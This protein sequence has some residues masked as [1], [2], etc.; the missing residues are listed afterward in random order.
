MRVCQFRLLDADGNEVIRGSAKE[1]KGKGYVNLTSNLFSY[2]VNKCLLKKKYK[3]EQLPDLIIK[4]KSE[5]RVE[6]F[7]SLRTIYGFYESDKEIVRGTMKELIEKGY[8]EPKTNLSAYARS[9]TR[10]YKNKY[11]IKVLGSLSLKD[12]KIYPY[13]N[14]HKNGV[15]NCEGEAI[16]NELEY[17]KMHLLMYGNTFTRIN[18]NDS[19]EELAKEGINIYVRSLKDRKGV[20]YLIK[21]V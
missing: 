11:Q 5:Q 3:V 2:A 8:C 7:K 1:L 4:G 6:S 10:R 20:G 13:K 17:L 18:P 12:G 21:R 19:R 14:N 16:T 15:L 9:Q